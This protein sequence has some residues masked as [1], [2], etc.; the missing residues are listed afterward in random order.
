M[1]GVGEGRLGAKIEEL[2]KEGAKA[3]VSYI[4]VGIGTNMMPCWSPSGNQIVFVSDRGGNWD[5]WVMNAN[6]ANVIQ[7]TND[8]QFEQHPVW[9]PNGQKIA[10]ERGS[11]V[12]VMD[13]NGASPLNLT[14]GV[15]AFNGLPT[16]SPNSQSIAFV[17]DG[18]IYRINAD[19]TGPAQLT[20]MGSCF[21]PHWSKSAAGNSAITFMSASSGNPEIY[22][23]APDGTGIT[24]ISNDAAAEELPIWAP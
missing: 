19:G 7:L 4:T 5:I 22:V 13:A 3:L 2:K 6:G 20:M 8:P 1:E 10:F 14:N 17:R 11:D 16:W 18:D 12:W 9:S 21:S 23:M 24:N 15:G